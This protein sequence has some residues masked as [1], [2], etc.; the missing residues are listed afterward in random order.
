[1]RRRETLMLCATNLTVSYTNTIFEVVY[2]F[3][4]VIMSIEFVTA[5]RNRHIKLQKTYNFLFR[6]GL[7]LSS[8]VLNTNN[9]VSTTQVVFLVPLKVLI[10]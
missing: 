6:R 10:Y 7:H 5:E 9:A 3:S 8:R 4:I 2:L 1:M